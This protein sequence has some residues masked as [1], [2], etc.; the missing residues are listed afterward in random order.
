MTY[1][2]VGEL[3][4]LAV[5]FRLR[6]CAESWLVIMIMMAEMVAPKARSLRMT[7]NILLNSVME[8]GISP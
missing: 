5:N 8:G 2:K 3:L 4:Y 6:T 7:V 1:L